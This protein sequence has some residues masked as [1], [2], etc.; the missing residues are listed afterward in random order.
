MTNQK[1][2]LLI[3]ITN[4][5]AAGAQKLAADHL[6]HFDR[7]RY[8]LA[9]LTFF[10]EKDKDNFFHLLP[11]GIN[12]YKLDFKNCYDIKN[13][14]RIFMV[15]KEYRPDVV[16][17]H[18]FFSNAVL[19]VFKPFFGYQIII[20]EHNTYVNKTRLQILADKILSQFTLKIIA[21]S[22]A[23]KD[24][25][26]KQ[27]KIN[28]QK[29]VVIPCAVDYDKIQSQMI[30]Y[31]QDALKQKLGFGKDD[32]FVINVARLVKQKN[33]K[34][35]IESFAEF[36]QKNFG[37]KLIILGEGPLYDDLNNYIKDLNL[38]GKVFLLGPK[39]NVVEYLFISDLF[40]LTSK[41][42]GFPIACLEALAVGLPVVSPN[43]SSFSNWLADGFNGYLAEG[44]SK[45]EIARAMEKVVKSGP[46]SFSKNCRVTA[47]KYDIK[48][49]IKEI[50]AIIPQ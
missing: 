39:R 29:F 16:I 3:G 33:H 34:L 12:N 13:W 30:G 47:R 4:F 24:F 35:L 22:E 43:L 32:K 42:E 15:L 7:A 21:D 9:L 49:N 28:P 1:I 11:G 19:R 40:V 5:T 37:Y 26:V 18:L 45:E 14:F 10:Q 46:A 17:S 2:K 41:V 23:I 36:S 31:D 48:N 27:E 20:Y 38:A 44:N 25:T 6:N 8:E 50:E